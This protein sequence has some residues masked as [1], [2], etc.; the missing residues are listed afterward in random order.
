MSSRADGKA[1]FEFVL[2][3]WM[4]KPGFKETG[5]YGKI[6]I[7]N[8]ITNVIPK[9]RRQASRFIFDVTDCPLSDNEIIQ[10][11][12]KLYFSRHTRFI[13]KIVIMRDG[14][15]RKAYERNHA[16]R[17]NAIKK[18]LAFRVYYNAL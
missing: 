5:S 18:F 2:R 17:K 8:D 14:E 9:K 1:A 16:S 3:C 15:I 6:R 13:D 7:M 11:V 12:E 10:K 4:V